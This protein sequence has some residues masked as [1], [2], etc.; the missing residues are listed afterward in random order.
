M[1]RSLKRAGLSSKYFFTSSVEG[2]AAPVA[3][4][5][6]NGKLLIS[7]TT[8]QPPGLVSV[9]FD[10]CLKV[11]KACVAPNYTA[12]W[13]TDAAGKYVK[14]LEHN[15]GR[16]QTSLTGYVRLGEDCVCEV[17]VVTTPT[18]NF[19]YQH[20]IVWNGRDAQ[21][22][23]VPYGTYNLNIELA[24]GN[25][26]DWLSPPIPFE[27]KPPPFTGQWPL[28]IPPAVPHAGVSLNYLPNP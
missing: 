17:D 15:G 27:I 20:D 26:Q 23:A 16:Y 28:L 10:D 6:I 18:K 25:N 21:G 11:D 4:G 2:C 8:S 7:F 13:L 3:T 9:N 24:I 12:I 19:H 5:S 14:M 1:R 22:N